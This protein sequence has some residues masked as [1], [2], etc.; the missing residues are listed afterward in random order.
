MREKIERYSRKLEGLSTEELS[1]SAEKLVSLQRR[2][3]AALIS[4]SV[5]VRA[6]RGSALRWRAWR[7]GFLRCWTISPRGR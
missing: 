6:R 3:D 4:T 7:G 5:S 1:R 2:N